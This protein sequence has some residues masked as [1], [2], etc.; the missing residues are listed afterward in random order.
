MTIL[1]VGKTFRQKQL[2]AVEHYE[3][4]NKQENS[5]GYAIKIRIKNKISLVMWINR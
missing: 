4:G 1:L 3:I 5:P 2:K